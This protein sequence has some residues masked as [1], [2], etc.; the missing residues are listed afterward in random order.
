MRALA[1]LRTHVFSLTLCFPSISMAHLASPLAQHLAAY[2][3]SV[4][5]AEEAAQPVYNP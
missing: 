1:V 4:K 3:P 2:K 5:G